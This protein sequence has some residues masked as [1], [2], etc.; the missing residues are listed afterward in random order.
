MCKYEGGK[1]R[2]NRQAGEKEERMK[3]MTAIED[4]RRKKWKQK[5]LGNG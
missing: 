2:R 3:K 4:A 1:A 5:A